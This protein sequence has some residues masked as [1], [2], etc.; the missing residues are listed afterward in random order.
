MRTY[1]DPVDVRQG[2]GAGLTDDGEDGPRQFLWR[3]RLW[4]VREVLAH[5]VENGAWWVRR[6]E[7]A[8]GRSALVEQREVW[9]VAAAR[10]RAVS[11]PGDPG[12]GVFDLAFDW[13]EGV[14]RLAGSLD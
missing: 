13:S 10:G 9:R 4:Q 2:P 5:W 12:C 1:D 8:P 7:D 3:G 14:W 6:P 11:S